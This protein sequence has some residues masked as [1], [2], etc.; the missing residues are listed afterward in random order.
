MRYKK[1]KEIKMENNSRN[2]VLIANYVLSKTGAIDALKL[3]KT[4]YFIEAIHLARFG[5]SLIDEDFEA[6]VHGPVLKNVYNAFKSQ[7]TYHSNIDK[8]GDIEGYKDLKNEQLVLINEIIE[9]C[10]DK[11]SSK[12]RSDSHDLVWL[13]TRK[14][15]GPNDNSNRKMDK[16]QIRS[17]YRKELAKSEN[18]D[19]KKVNDDLQE[20]IKKRILK[21]FNKTWIE[22]AK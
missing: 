21:R 12:L 16:K 6:W 3:Q 8:S 7:S 5:T 9:D 11:S 18:K 20:S 2:S 15:L 4:L 13:Q 1:E 10:V 17:H 14:G 22:L 19:L